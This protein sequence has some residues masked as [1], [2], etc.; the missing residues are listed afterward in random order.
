M[1]KKHSFGLGIVIII[2]GTFLLFQ[3][4]GLGLRFTAIDPVLG[5]IQRYF[6]PLFII[7]AGLFA[8]FKTRSN[9]CS[10]DLTNSSEQLFNDH[11]DEA[12]TYDNEN[13]SFFIDADDA[14]YHDESSHNQPINQYNYNTVLDSNRIVIAENDLIDGLNLVQLNCTLG[15]L[16]L[17]LPKSVNIV[18]EAYANF[19]EI[20]FL[21]KK[22]GSTRGVDR[23]KY[24]AQNDST[25]RVLIKAKANFA[26]IKITLHE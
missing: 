5:A 17:A 18:L 15:E 9:N 3:N 24:T 23:A 16:Q 20:K 11:A 13:D 22:Y 25:K 19:A 4:I 12:Y 8:F 10:P 26:E 14:S 6:L 21:D 2:I 7:A 1:F